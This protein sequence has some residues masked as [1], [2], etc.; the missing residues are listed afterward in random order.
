MRRCGISPRGSDILPDTIY[1]ELHG[2]AG[3]A[4]DVIVS[5]DGQTLSLRNDVEKVWAKTTVPAT[6]DQMLDD[7]ARRYSLPVPIADVV[8]SVPYEAFIGRT[9]TGGL[10]GRETIDDT[11]CTRLVF[12]DEFV[13]VTVWLPSSG[14][15]LPR[16][17]ELVYKR[18]PGAPKARID[19]T[20]WDLSPK[21]A[22]GTFRFATND[23]TTQVAFE[24]IVA[25]LLSGQHVPGP[26]QP[27]RSAPGA[28][29]TVTDR[30]VSRPRVR[31]RAA[32]VRQGE[33][34]SAGGNQG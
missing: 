13:D 18:A 27:G 14:Q 30:D 7:V 21:I 8:Y 19:F 17:V 29:T 31:L 32:N 2:A 23:A 26:A 1:F 12:T 9:A 22:D 20:S 24:D 25:G 6:L 11:A 16:R 28:A 4:L 3:T 5:Y 33:G 10:V 15:P 34:G